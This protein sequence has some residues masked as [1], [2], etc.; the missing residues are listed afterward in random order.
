MKIILLFT[1][2]RS[3]SDL[4]Q[5]LL[6]GHPEV[7][8]FPAILNFTKDFLK[9]FDLKDP[10]IIAQKFI[11]L[12]KLYFDSRLNKIERHNKLGKKKNEFYIVDK[13]LFIQNFLSIYNKSKKKKLDILVCLH[14]AYML[15]RNPKQKK[16]KIILLHIHLFENFKNYLKVFNVFRDTKILITYRDPLVS[17]CSTVKHWTIYGEGRYM[18]PRQLYTNYQFHFNIFNNLKRY[19]NKTRVVKLEKIHTR[20]KKTLKRLSKFIGIRYSNTLLCSTYFDKKWWGDSISKKYLNGLNSE[21]KNKFDKKIFKSNELEFIENKIIN[22][23]TKYNYPIRTKVITKVDKYY[24][25]LFTLE[26]IF[27]IKILKKFNLKTKFSIIFFYLKR[28]YLFRKKFLKENL[29]YEI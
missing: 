21:F 1:G 26:K 10:K 20:S 24:F 27:Y 12:N 3:G 4:L 5:S 7:A 29:P 19:K 14:K 15:C 16:L 23:L 22:I 6:D 18:T 8:Q 13:I 25:P 11:E 2:G 28:L 17:M 9:I